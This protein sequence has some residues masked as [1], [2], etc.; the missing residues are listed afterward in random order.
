MF[1]RNQ[2]LIKKI[3]KKALIE[4]EKNSKRCVRWKKIAV[5]VRKMAALNS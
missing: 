3:L 2:M 1:N 5:Q 4:S